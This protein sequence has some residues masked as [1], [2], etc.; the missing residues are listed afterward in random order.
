MKTY[1]YLQKIVCTEQVNA[2]N[3]EKLVWLKYVD[4]QSDKKHTNRQTGIQISSQQELGYNKVYTE[5][6]YDV[7]NEK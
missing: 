5:T 4:I 2:Q 7:I 1:S 6:L 3:G